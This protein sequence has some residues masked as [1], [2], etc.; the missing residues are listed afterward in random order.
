M[1]STVKERGSALRVAQGGSVVVWAVSTCLVPTTRRE[2]I[3]PIVFEVIGTNTWTQS[4][5]LRGFPSSQKRTT[6][7]A[8][9]SVAIYNQ[10]ERPTQWETFYCFQRHS[11]GIDSTSHPHPPRLRLLDI[12]DRR[13]TPSPN[14]SEAHGRATL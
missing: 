8:R 12:D 1:Q 11:P 7:W 14:G 2:I 4:V 3:E 13:S 6:H 10:V 9:S 5:Y